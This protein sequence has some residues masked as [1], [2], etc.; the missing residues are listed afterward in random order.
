MRREGGG[1]HDVGFARQQC[2]RVRVEDVPGLAGEE[3]VEAH[4][5]AL[6]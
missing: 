2:Q 3:A 5:L 6:R 4:E 1:V